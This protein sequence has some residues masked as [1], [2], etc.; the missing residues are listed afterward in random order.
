MKCKICGTE[1]NLIKVKDEEK[2]LF[3]SV[4]I[5]MRASVRGMKG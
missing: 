1:E 3:M 5:A 2:I 4:R